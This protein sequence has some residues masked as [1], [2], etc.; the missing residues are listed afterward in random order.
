MLF[1]MTSHQS[2]SKGWVALL[3]SLMQ[4][5]CAAPLGETTIDWFVRVANA[6]DMANTRFCVSS[7]P[8]TEDGSNPTKKGPAHMSCGASLDAIRKRTISTCENF[9]KTK[10]MAVY[11]FE[12]G[13]D[14]FVKDFERENMA[15]KAAEARRIQLQAQKAEEQRLSSICTKYGFR[16]DTPDHA[17][18]VMKQTQHEQVMRVQQERLAVENRRKEQQDWDRRVE[19]LRRASEM[20]KNDGSTPGQSICRPNSSGVLI[21]R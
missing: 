4:M 1:F 21:C 18:C 6:P 16:T 8:E 15:R 2:K 11:Y 10:C 5:G 3:L 12:K 20:L 9:Q 13:K 14:E 17:H 7:A 19:G